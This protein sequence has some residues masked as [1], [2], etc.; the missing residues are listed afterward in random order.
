[1]SLLIFAPGVKEL[2][3]INYGIKCGKLSRESSFKSPLTGEKWREAAFD[4]YIGLDD[5]TL[6]F[7]VVYKDDPVGYTEAKYKEDF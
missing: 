7:F 6:H 1:M 2:C 3:R 4:L 5:A